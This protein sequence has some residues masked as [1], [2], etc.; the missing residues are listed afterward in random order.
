MTTQFRSDPIEAYAADAA[1]AEL[2]TSLAEHA[3][4][5]SRD[6]DRLG[7]AIDAVVGPA[8]GDRVPSLE[9]R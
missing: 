3:A 8:V 7:E 4:V 9:R 1:L 2:R 5:L 6:A